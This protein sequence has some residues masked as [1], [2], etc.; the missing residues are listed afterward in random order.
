ME[1]AVG[2][3]REAFSLLIDKLSYSGT[4]THM[5]GELLP[6]DTRLRLAALAYSFK[7]TEVLTQVVES[8]PLGLD[9]DGAITL[10][11]ALTTHPAMAAVRR[12][13][14]AVLVMGIEE[15][16]RNVAE[17][18]AVRAAVDV[19]AY[20]LGPVAAMFEGKGGADPPLREEVKQ[21]P[22]Y[23]FKRLL[24]SEA[25]QLQSENEAYALLAAWA[26]HSPHVGGGNQ[27]IEAFK[28]LAPLLRYHHM[29]LDFLANYVRPSPLRVKSG[30]TMPTLLPASGGAASR[31]AASPSRAEWQLKASFT[32]EEVEALRP[33]G[34]VGKWCGLAVGYP[35]ACNVQRSEGRDRLGVCLCIAL[36]TPQGLGAG[37]GSAMGVDL[38]VKLNFPTTSTPLVEDRLKRDEPWGYTDVFNKPW[39]RVVRAGSPEFPGGKLEV[40]VTIKLPA[41]A[42]MME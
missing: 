36:P 28:E 41:S 6:F 7:F 20:C 40:R 23:I 33:G 29:T 5:D 21:L 1:T 34:V 24:A 9:F 27:R 31:G 12:Q 26:Y 11:P 38:K 4:Y 19:L 8:L 10:P 14:V 42:A 25:L 32:L 39:S 17:E 2:S 16:A 13:V 22:L 37:G 15:R 3:E 30:L 35:I 18:E